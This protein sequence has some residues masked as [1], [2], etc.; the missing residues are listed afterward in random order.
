MARPAD[1]T[2][3]RDALCAFSRDH[4]DHCGPAEADGA[5]AAAVLDHEGAVE[6][7]LGDTETY[8]T[9]LEAFAQQI[10]RFLQQL[11]RGLDDADAPAL[12]VAA[13]S[14]R[15][16]SA[17]IGAEA[18][19]EQAEAV[20]RAAQGGDAPAAS[21]MAMTLVARLCAV[22][23]ALAQHAGKDACEDGA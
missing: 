4:A 21:R 19:R 13:H 1:F 6:R 12:A 5:R 14:L 22:A 15:G 2:A 18:V 11:A 9:L 3:L 7:L 8:A 20:E 10:P 23:E 17:A 16:T